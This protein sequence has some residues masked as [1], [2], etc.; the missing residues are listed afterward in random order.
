MKAIAVFQ[1]KLKGSYCSFYQD[2]PKFPVKINV[3]VK[4]LT[5]GKHGVHVH[6]LGNLLK[7]DCSEC[8][9]HWNPY[10]RTHGG[11]ND[12]NSHAGDL[13]NIIA[14]NPGQISELSRRSALYRARAYQTKGLFNKMLILKTLHTQN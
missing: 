5:P 6:E 8:K 7:T 12:I 4:G 9:G 3:H 13:G 10:N 1:G 14:N 2:D 11:L